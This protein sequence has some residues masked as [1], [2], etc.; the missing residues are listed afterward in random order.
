L[1]LDPASL[2]LSSRKPMN[3]VGDAARAETVITDPGATRL[4]IQFT[5]PPDDSMAQ[6]L[7]TFD[8]RTARRSSLMSSLEGTEKARGALPSRY[9]P[10]ELL[11]QG[12]MGVVVAAKDRDLARPVALKQLRSGTPSVD[13]VQRFLREAQVTAQLEHP[14]I[15]PVHDVGADEAGQFYY[16]MRLVKGEQTLRRI[17]ELLR[18]G[19]EEAHRTF[20]VER[21]VRIVQQVAH[22]LHYAHTRG[23]VHRD[24]KPENIMVGP[25]GEVYLLDWGLAKLN[26]QVD[27]TIDISAP[28][29]K[30]SQT[31]EGRIVG[32]PLY[33]APEQVRG[34]AVTPRTDVYSLS[35]VLY[36]IL[37]L[38]HYLGDGIESTV[39]LLSAVEQR[40]PEP[41][42]KLQNGING[43][44]SR[45]LA[46]VCDR[47]LEKRPEDRYASAQALEEALQRC[48]EG[49]TPVLCPATLLLHI[50]DTWRRAIVRSPFLMTNVTFVGPL[51][52]LAFYLLIHFT[53]LGRW[54]F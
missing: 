25:F 9:E 23:V 26:G 30:D 19:D 53:R 21:R 24:V 4:D 52:V 50:L 29:G 44:V 54:V 18:S 45:A 20:T 37:T 27:R 8:P 6:T 33:M 41:A 32:T 16:V 49:A 17:V 28:A 2:K 46:V 10:G 42:W 3:Q 1:S 22:I 15:V 14:G 38:E 34:A 35:A 12:G 13:L 7:E 36:E 31:Q 11:G 39:E 5:V 47:G 43:R 40:E 51:V 48:L